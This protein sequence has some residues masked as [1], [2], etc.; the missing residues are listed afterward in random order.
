MFFLDPKEGT[1]E[2][3]AVIILNICFQVYSQ[4]DLCFYIAEMLQN[5]TG[6][7]GNGSLPRLAFSA[8]LGIV[9][10]IIPS[11]VSSVQDLVGDSKELEKAIRLYYAFVW[12]TTFRIPTLFSMYVLLNKMYG[13][14]I[15]L[16]HEYLASQWGYVMLIYIIQE[17]LAEILCRIADFMLSKKWIDYFGRFSYPKVMLKHYQNHGLY[18]CAAFQL[19]GATMTYPAMIKL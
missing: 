13:I 19:V 18:V 3:L 10:S 9:Q 2:L 14:K 4:T 1:L 8:V 7:N 15:S 16:S 6:T 12:S 5:N 17:V 11:G